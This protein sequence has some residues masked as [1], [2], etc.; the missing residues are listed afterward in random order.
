MEINRTKMTTAMRNFDISWKDDLKITSSRRRF[1]ILKIMRNLE[2]I[3]HIK[4]IIT[5]DLLIL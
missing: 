2:Y 5:S 3:A 1:I 4:S